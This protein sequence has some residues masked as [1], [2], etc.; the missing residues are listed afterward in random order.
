MQYFRYAK[1]VTL[2]VRPFALGTVFFSTVSLLVFGLI[3][4]TVSIFH[5]IIAISCIKNII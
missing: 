5:K 4:I 2:A 1:E 3:F